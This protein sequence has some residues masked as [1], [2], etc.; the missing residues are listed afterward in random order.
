MEVILKVAIMANE[1]QN[2]TDEKPKKD[3]GE[4]S[5][6]QKQATT[7]ESESEESDDSSVCFL[8]FI[9]LFIYLFGLYLF[10]E[11]KKIQE[12]VMRV[13]KRWLSLLLSKTGK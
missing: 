5:E 11:N 2:T 1:T 12:K 7:E 8:L 9:Y 4:H 13:K 6:E 10:L 3:N